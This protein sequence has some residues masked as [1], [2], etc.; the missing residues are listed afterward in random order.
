[1]KKILTI[2]LLIFTNSVKSQNDSLWNLNDISNITFYLYESTTRKGGSATLISHKKKY[3]ILTAEH[4]A[5]DMT[6]KSLLVMRGDNDTPI[7]YELSSLTNENKLEWTNHKEADL[8]IIELSNLDEY[9]T[10]RFQKWCFPS[11]LILKEKKTTARDNDVTF[12][13]FPIIDTDLQHFSPLSFTAYPASG[14]LTNKRYDTNTKCTFFYVDQPSMQ[15]CSG[16]G[17]YFSVEKAEFY[18]IGK[19]ILIGVVHGTAKDN[20]GGKLAAITPSFYIWDLLK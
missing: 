7:I 16:A 19:T 17:V 8:S 20:T 9:L 18:S 5:K 13:G 1:M 11:E 12:F 3:F 14:L 2:V 4:I 10:V 6:I 15:G